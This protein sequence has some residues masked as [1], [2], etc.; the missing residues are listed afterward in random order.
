M[1]IIS[2]SDSFKGSLTSNQT[3]EIIS[4]AAKEVSEDIE[5]I[6]CPIA[7]GGEGTLDAVLLSG[8]FD[9]LELTVKNPLFE[10]IKA[11][12]AMKGKVAFV[13]M[14]QAS[15][16]TLIPYKDGNAALTTT[17]GTGQLIADAVKR[18]AEQIYVAVGGSATNDG[19]TGALA[20]LG[21][22]FLDK[23]GAELEPV[24]KNLINIARIDTAGFSLPRETKLTVLADVDNPLVGERGATRYYGRQ[25]GAVGETA[26]MLESGMIHY[27]D[28]VEKTLGIR[29]HDKPF[30]G[31]A[32]GLSGGLMA[33]AGAAVASGIE[34]V[35]RLTG[36][37][38]KIK[39]ADVVITGEGRLDGQS[40]CGKAISGVCS[41]AKKHGVPVYAIVGSTELSQAEVSAFG[42]KKVETLIS[43]S[44]SLEDAINNAPF[45]MERVAKRMIELIYKSGDVL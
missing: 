10:P 18:G 32:G 42:I 21:V 25:K 12:Y 30:A 28:V 44:D 5:V 15:G 7:D 36:F 4:L 37:E 8:G 20:A 1:R 26:D 6:A 35:L 23:N 19:G 2:A 40:L 34:S 9:E 43:D 22:R 27:A 31:A 39:T 3:A 16:L 14:A 33:F 45:H 11:R 29:L 17:Y 41:P 13:E 38:D 24:G